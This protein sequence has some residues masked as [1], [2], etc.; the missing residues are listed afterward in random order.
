HFAIQKTLCR[1]IRV[2]LLL[3]DS[4]NVQSGLQVAT[5]CN[6]IALQALSN[7]VTR[8]E[9]VQAEFFEWAFSSPL[10]YLHGGNDNDNDSANAQDIFCRVLSLL[11]TTTG[12]D[13]STKPVVATLV[14]VYNS[15]HSNPSA[16]HTLASTKRGRMLIRAVAE[17]FIA[18]EDNDS[19]VKQLS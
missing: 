1:V 13:D 19:D 11:T 5:R 17:I 8:D 12:F 4:F 18:T 3:L 15:I 10:L 9:H 14:L 6:V 2:T 7:S 16:R